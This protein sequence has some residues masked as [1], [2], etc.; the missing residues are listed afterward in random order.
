MCQHWERLA[1]NL[2]EKESQLKIIAKLVEFLKSVGDINNEAWKSDVNIDNMEK[3]S[4]PTI[5]MGVRALKELAN[6]DTITALIQLGVLEAVGIILITFTPLWLEYKLHEDILQ[7]VLR[8][9]HTYSKY[10]CPNTIAEVR[11][12]VEYYKNLNVYTCFFSYK[13]LLKVILCHG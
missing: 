12:Y 3:P 11:V 13:I 8:L 10:K 4:P 2:L 9:I 6:M 5:I 7:V 1:N